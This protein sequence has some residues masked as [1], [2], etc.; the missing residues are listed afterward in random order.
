MP[1]SVLGGQVL[2]GQGKP[3]VQ[4]LCLL[5][6]LTLVDKPVVVQVAG[7]LID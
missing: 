3:G 4:G 5:V 2:A 1:V 6:E 7:R